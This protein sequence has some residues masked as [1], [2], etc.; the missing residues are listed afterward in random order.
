M[1]PIP[2]TARAIEEYGPFVIENEDL[3]V[4]LLNKAEQV[5]AF[6]PQCLGVSLASNEDAVTFT[7]VASK[8]ELAVLDAVQYLSDGPCVQAVREPQVLAFEQQDLFDEQGWRLFAEAS[9]AASVASTLTFPIVQHGRVLGSVNLYASTPHA[10][11]GYREELAGIFG[12]WAPGAVSNADLE[13]RSRE[14]AAAAPDLLRDD[15]DLAVASGMIAMRDGVGIEESTRR[16]R[17]AAVRAGVSE[18]ELARTVISTQRAQDTD[19][20]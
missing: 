6:V 19:D 20:E 18:L 4:E 5:R 1:E 15:L 8:K 13:F 11:D 9:A 7:V 17:A 12:A 14:V 3:L 16:L 10:F 2:E